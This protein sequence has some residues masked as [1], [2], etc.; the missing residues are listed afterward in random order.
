MRKRSPKRRQDASWIWLC[1]LL[2]I[3]FIFIIVSYGR[4][5]L[6]ANG[7][8][9]KTVSQ[10][11]ES[12]KLTPY[13]PPTL[14]SL[15]V[16]PESTDN[17]FDFILDTQEEPVEDEDSL[18][19]IA[20]ELID[21]FFLGITLP[22]D[23]LWVNLN[24]VRQNAITSPRLA[25]TDIGKV[26]LE[27][28]L[29]LKKDCCRFTDPRTKTGKE[30]WGKLQ[31][32]LN[33]ANLSTS[34]LPIGNRFWII[35]EEA[36]VEENSDN[37][38]VTI[39]KSKLKVCLQQEYL[40]LQNNQVTLLSD[41]NQ[42]PQ[43]RLAQDIADFTMKEVILP[44]IQEEVNYGK[45]YAKLRQVYNSLILAEYY[46]QKYHHG[47][48]LY[49]KLINRAHIQGLES[50]E[51]WN[52]Q[53]FY[54]A[55]VKSAQEGEY[56]LTQQEYDPY[57]ASMVQKYYFYGGVLISKLRD[58]LQRRVKDSSSAMQKQAEALRI[59]IDKD[60]EGRYWYVRNYTQ[61]QS[62]WKTIIKIFRG[63]K[64]K[65]QVEF[66]GRPIESSEKYRLKQILEKFESESNVVPSYDES[67]Y[68]SILSDELCH[69]VGWDSFIASHLDNNFL[70]RESAF[71]NDNL[72]TITLLLPNQFR[73][74]HSL[75]SL[76]ALNEKLMTFGLY[77]DSKG[78]LY[79]IE[80]KGLVDTDQGAVEVLYVHLIDKYPDGEK[81]SGGFSSHSDNRIVI[82]RDAIKRQVTE[83]KQVL[84]SMTSVD[85]S[86]GAKLV[87]IALLKKGL[88]SSDF[89]ECC[90]LVEQGI[91]LHE[92]KHE[93]CRRMLG[94]QAKVKWPVLD[95]E[96]AE[97]Y[98]IRNA[99][100]PFHILANL[101]GKIA[102]QQELTEEEA[103]ERQAAVNVLIRLSK[104]RNMD[105]FPWLSFMVE[106][107]TKE[108]LNDAA[109]VAYVDS[110]EVW[111]EQY[112]KL[113]HQF[114]GP[115]GGLHAGEVEPAIRR[116]LK[117][118]PGLADKSAE[119][120]LEHLKQHHEGIFDAVDKAK[121]IEQVQ[122][123]LDIKRNSLRQFQYLT[124]KDENWPLIL[125]FFQDLGVQQNY[126]IAHVGVHAQSNMAIAA[127]YLEAHYT[128]YEL[129]LEN[130]SRNQEYISQ[131]LNTPQVAK[132][133]PGTIK[134]LQGEFSSGEKS[135]S[136]SFGQRSQDVVLIISGA[137]SDPYYP[138]SDPEEV[139]IESLRVIKS[140]GRLA[141]GTYG[142]LSELKTAEE[143]MRRVLAR[144]E[145][146]GVQ[147]TE[148][149]AVDYKESLHFRARIYKVIFP[150]DTFLRQ[151]NPA[152]VD[153]RGIE[154]K[155]ESKADF[156]QDRSA[157]IG[158]RSEPSEVKS[159]QAITA[160]IKTD[161]GEIDV[162]RAAMEGI[163]NFARAQ[164]ITLARDITS[165]CKIT[166]KEHEDGK[167]L[168]AIVIS[169]PLDVSI[170]TELIIDDS[171]YRF[172]KGRRIMRGAEY[173]IPREE[174][175]EEAVDHNTRKINIVAPGVLEAIQTEITFSV[176]EGVPV[177]LVTEQKRR[178]NR[179][180]HGA[181]IIKKDIDSGRNRLEK[182]TP[183][184]QG[185]IFSVSA[186]A[187]EGQSPE[188]A[189]EKSDNF[190]KSFM[191]VLSEKHILSK[192]Y[193]SLED[194]EVQ[195]VVQTS[196]PKIFKLS[197]FSVYH[198]LS[199]LLTDEAVVDLFGRQYLNKREEITDDNITGKLKQVQIIDIKRVGYWGT[200]ATPYYTGYSRE[201]IFREDSR[202]Y[203][204]D[205]QDFVAF[206]HMHPKGSGPEYFYKLRPLWNDEVIGDFIKNNYA[207]ISSIPSSGDLR[208]WYEEIDE[209]MM[210]TPTGGLFFP[211]R[212]IVYHRLVVHG[213]GDDLDADAEDKASFMFYQIP[214]TT[215]KREEWLTL[216]KRY[217]QLLGRKD[218]IGSYR[219]T[220]QRVI[221]LCRK[222]QVK[223]EVLKQ[224][225]L[226][227]NQ[228]EGDIDEISPEVFAR[229][230]DQGIGIN[231]KEILQKCDIRWP[232]GE[233]LSAGQEGLSEVV[234]DADESGGYIICNGRRS[235]FEKVPGQS[236]YV[237]S[238][239]G[240][241]SEIQ[242]LESLEK[243][244]QDNETDNTDFGGVDF[245]KIEIKKEE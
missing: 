102:V 70:I 134:Y 236:Y 170:Y 131:L 184:T 167:T 54:Q 105:V 232:A 136:K 191:M 143:V 196:L 238:G 2:A 186:F 200:F 133:L 107:G 9:Q 69:N 222:Y 82:C 231:I 10:V 194:G 114:G 87:G 182:I 173:P 183:K 130:F 3:F 50:N 165:L 187:K 15:I 221:E 71:K 73:W 112:A 217:D 169:H 93:V 129:D 188:E 241:I 128:G 17:Y 244:K 1:S 89:K 21:Y 119:E 213:S 88:G 211:M 65:D 94:G 64:P 27:A 51:P 53:D 74:E 162:T 141:V 58:V 212:G 125:T 239:A 151:K 62:P 209:Q 116:I 57:L 20:K 106:R 216:I 11:A 195:L 48:G 234:M 237:I 227:D 145:W 61:P 18:E 142:W 66:A 132:E 193:L 124:E 44:A 47:Q 86:K 6:R 77:V 34:Q 245:R 98:T 122:N 127:A 108:D 228:F 164:F 123:I 161:Q 192:A 79:E 78:T 72:L 26:L 81:R 75:D 99:E 207:D 103:R 138:V 60:A 166:K 218:D 33:E 83:I 22:S 38:T 115:S 219:Q 174:I 12:I 56:K 220:I 242:L 63:K 24:S 100:E 59:E 111:I 80:D 147:L 185:Q 210:A 243:F 40:E 92:V 224:D 153:F 157:G 23:D 101:V 215:K 84:N 175:E 178:I 226:L 30:Y 146:K 121:R 25:L 137:L 156:G 168:Y 204:K 144:P 67:S 43:A 171:D 181:A 45:A 68:V 37:H 149:W 206:L 85:I 39:V 205:D 155:G 16:H 91:L 52:T 46:K 197:H 202:A 139:F 35:P 120:L 90:R 95:E 190:L 36:V 240:S 126:N 32:R 14:K 189:K 76:R 180:L 230:W 158:G 135:Q 19:P 31:A 152:G 223:P 4:G 154:S 96:F 225:K 235:H 159:K 13:T 49:P 104:L 109:R 179:E 150:E 5:S 199:E 28:D 208:G 160:V 148:E 42:H 172:F 8:Y 201:S 110:E 55:Y 140:G 97:L 176:A 177:L 118:D 214:E 113:G 163:Q 7:S 233:R 198:K 229:V 117:A 203:T 41:Q 29:T